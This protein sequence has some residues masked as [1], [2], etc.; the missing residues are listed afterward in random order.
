[1]QQHHHSPQQ[2][3]P[4][5]R[6]APSALAQQVRGLQLTPRRV[7]YR[8]AFKSLGFNETICPNT[9]QLAWGLY[10]IRAVEHARVPARTIEAARRVLRRTIGKGAML[11]IRMTPNI[12][13]T[14]KPAE[15]RMG[16]GKGAVDYWASPV[17]PGQ[18][19]FEMDRLPRKV[20]LGVVAALQPKLPMRIG[21]VE[22]T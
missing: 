16:K 11:W 6:G 9:R 1:L 4:W 5:L 3:N 7:K 18:I 13:V 19:I 15:V 20:A 10:G 8:K 22:Y 12:P 17:R 14:S 21:F 2:Q